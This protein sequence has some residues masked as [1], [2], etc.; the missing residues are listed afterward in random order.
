MNKN[1][2]YIYK[3]YS[4]LNY[5]LKYIYLNKKINLIITNIIDNKSNYKTNIIKYIFFMKTIIKYKNIVKKYNQIL[6]II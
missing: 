3:S 4:N 1:Q 2:I 5:V 6:I